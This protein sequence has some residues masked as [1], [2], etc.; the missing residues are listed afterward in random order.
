MQK[1]R[2]L[3][4]SLILAWLICASA[5]AQIE[6]SI[7]SGAATGVNLPLNCK[8][9]YSYSQ[10]IYT[11]AQINT[12]GSIH[13][14]SFYYSSG[15]TANSNAWV[16]YMGHT[17]KTTFT[18]NSDWVP[19]IAMTQVYSGNVSF[20]SSAGWM[21]IT[22]STP[23]D[24]NNINNLVIAVDEN[25]SGKANNNANW[26][27][28]T[29]GTDTGIYYR[30]NSNFNPA[31]P[32]NA[33][34]RTASINRIKL[35]LAGI[36]N[37]TSLSANPFS[38]SQIDLQWSKNS[39]NNNV[40]IAYNSVNSF[41]TPQTGSNYNAGTA[42][43]GGGTV[44]YNGSAS[45]FSHTG[46]T[47]GTTYFYKAWSVAS[48]EYSTGITASATT[49]AA[50]V[51]SYPYTESFD[52]ELFA[53]LGWTNIKTAGSGTP[54]IWDRQT[55]GTYPSCTP[56][57][58]A[59]MARFNSYSYAAG[60]TAQLISRPLNL[61]DDNYKVT[62]YMVRDNGYT[63]SADKLNV[64]YNSTN[65]STGA[66][67]LGTIHRSITLSPVVSE[68][69]WYEYSFIMPA[70]SAGNGRYLIFEAVSGYGNNIFMDHV[71]VS[72][73]PPV[74]GVDSIPGNF[75][76]AAVNGASPLLNYNLYNLGGG[77]LNV[78]APYLSGADAD[79]FELT[80]TGSYP[81]SLSSG[82]AVGYSLQFKPTSLGIKNASMLINDNLGKTLW[83]V[84][85]SGEAMNLVATQNFD[86]FS[87]FSLVLSPWTQFDADGYASYGITGVTFPNSTYTG[88]FI[89]F[90]PTQTTPALSSTYNALSGNQYAACFAATTAP[91]N[92]WLISPQLSFNRNPK[93]SFFA[94]SLVDTY[95]L[96]RFSV[97]V[98][99]TDN[100]IASFSKISDGDYLE[101]PLS[102]TG[103]TF[104]LPSNCADNANVYVA[105]RCQSSDAFIFMVD[106][107]GAWD[108]PAP[109][110]GISPTA[111]D[112]DTFYINYTRSATF[113]IKNNGGDGL[114]INAGGIVLSGNKYFK[115]R[116]LETLP[117]TLNSGETFAFR[118]EY[119]PSMGGFH[120]AV[121]SVTDNLGRAV[122]SLPISGTAIDNTIKQR[123][124]FQ[125]FEGESIEGW[126]TRDADA[127]GRHW[128]QAN[129]PGQS[130]SGSYFAASWS[131]T[132]DAKFSSGL[133]TVARL[134]QAS[135]SEKQS[136]SLNPSSKLG[137][138]PDNWLIS[139]PF[140]IGRG[141]S[142]TYWMG[143][144]ND[145]LCG[146]TYTLYISTES[147]E[148][149]MFQ[150]LFSETLS[151]S[152]WQY[153][154]F[155][156]DA[157]QE[158]VVYFAFRHHDST[159]LHFLKMDE[160]KVLA[161]NTEINQAL[162]V[163]GNAAMVINPIQDIDLQLPVSVALDIAGV[164]SPI[165]TANVS[166]ASPSLELPDPGMCVYV[167]G[168]PFS[169][170][171]FTI[172]HNLGY[173]PPYASWRIVP[174][175]WNRIDAQSDYVSLWTDQSIS[176]VIPAVKAEGDVEVVFPAGSDG[177][178]PVELSHFSVTINSGSKVTV[179]WVSES[180]SNLTGYRIYRGN[181]NDFADAILLDG[182]IT[183]TNTSQQQ[184]YVYTDAE[185]NS[186]GKFYYW[187]EHLEMDGGS[188]IHGP[189]SIDVNEGGNQNPSIPVITGIAS[190]Y[191]NPFNPDTMIRFG[192]SQSANFELKIYNYR[193]QLVRNLASGNL[194]RG[195]YKRLWDG[196]DD[197]GSQ[198]SSGIYFAVLNSGKDSFTRKMM[199]VK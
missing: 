72:A 155:S 100:Q 121:L 141:D 157:Y 162:V 171:T 23:F 84:S 19:V 76:I 21:E 20:P 166:Y 165:V 167:T 116:D 60:T 44:L 77:I 106:D 159:N 15:S 138:N 63:S 85:L 117:V 3:T 49:L 38:S 190:I 178:L 134:Q 104:N 111:Y 103:Y 37:P 26:G 24:Y 41:G 12:A 68:S 128:Y 88:S 198:C 18:S 57:S 176:F 144:L 119:L 183:A 5:W 172:H 150:P 160:F 16:I 91:N 154:S 89:A 192:L 65:S 6:L 147:P 133:P 196:R 82:Q 179:T 8:N 177:T 94:K 174:G 4:I 194:E 125:G 187:L 188:F 153:R 180:E 193:G 71:V 53:P 40:M 80:L 93:I 79:Q 161:H 136:R 129:T 29:S 152:A 108:Y 39:S 61:P 31:S 46:L 66:T 78:S 137:I 168:G 142:L 191:P 120:E 27:V 181:S 51:S 95:G 195:Y 69:A 113:T 87:P 173:L 42:L 112:F 110:F 149:A 70:G 90:N 126:V 75:G 189:L 158:N 123:P 45:S 81:A 28:F 175:D 33:D 74:L 107:F 47:D 145:N 109:L 92:D 146:E 135:Q 22:L 7:G 36:S 25:T 10:Q 98:S 30:G 131:V 186:S 56:P 184:T 64:Y 99:T 9:N 118:I 58:G 169:G 102:W 59:G 140:V 73:N 96:E 114:V 35:N 132:D 127:D 13:K 86:S 32:T 62:F 143:A 124:Y 67:L 14:L 101:A 199:M 97:W 197:K 130:R 50:P 151:T 11:Q 148:T 139:P 115:L 163:S 156:L 185:L 52:S 105:I 83:S 17:T 2:L 54:G 34:G 43:A 182:F 170:S 55:A 1:L 164:S 48:S 122:T